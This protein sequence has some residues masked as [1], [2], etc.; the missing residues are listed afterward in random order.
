MRN[1]Q[2]FPQEVLE[3]K[4]RLQEAGDKRIHV[5]NLLT[6]SGKSQNIYEYENMWEIVKEASKKGRHKFL[7]DEWVYC[8]L[9]AVIY[10]SK[11]LPPIFYLTEKRKK[12]VLLR[13]QKYT[14]GLQLIY[15]DLCLDENLNKLELNP[16]HMLK[17][18]LEMAEKKIQ[19]ST[20]RGK[21]GKNDR[22]IR[23]VRNLSESNIMVYGRCLHAVIRAATI[24]IYAIEYGESDIDN[25]ISRGMHR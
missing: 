13:L 14:K 7:G 23:F 3:V 19:E 24:A 4:K 1:K 17:T 20:Q 12:E 6:K 18:Y 15:R 8:F 2:N 9:D 16:E 22:A 5:M 25:L 21:R 10:N 11:E